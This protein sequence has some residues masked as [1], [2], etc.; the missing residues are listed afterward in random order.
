MIAADNEGIGVVQDDVI[1][2]A[3]ADLAAGRPILA[4]EPRSTALADLI[5]HPLEDARKVGR[6]LNEK[7][8]NPHQRTATPRA[9][10]REQ[11]PVQLIEIA[12]IL[13]RS[14]VSPETHHHATEI[15]SVQLSAAADSAYGVAPHL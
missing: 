9:P 5:P 7:I 2:Y 4:V 14:D 13:S 15:F 12:Y 10:C 11:I 8:N 1:A 3:R 6:E